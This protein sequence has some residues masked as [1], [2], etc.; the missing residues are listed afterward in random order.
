[1]KR[2]TSS[3]FDKFG[4]ITF[5]FGNMIS[6]SLNLKLANGSKIECSQVITLLEGDSY[7]TLVLKIQNALPPAFNWDSSKDLIRYQRN[8]SQEFATISPSSEFYD[9]LAQIQVR[10]ISFDTPIVLWIFG[11]LGPHSQPTI[12]QNQ[13]DHSVAIHALQCLSA[14]SR[15][16]SQSPLSP[17]FST[18]SSHQSSYKDLHLNDS[19]LDDIEQSAG[20]PINQSKFYSGNRKSCDSSSLS[21]KRNSV[22]EAPILNPVP[23]LSFKRKYEHLYEAR[24]QSPKRRIK[25]LT[26]D[27]IEYVILNVKLNGAAVELPI[28]LE[29]LKSVLEY[30]RKQ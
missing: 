29:S 26:V 30:T 23:R 18:S 24:K 11:S 28:E 9:L 10:N 7:A 3:I 27:G 6:V 2:V 17:V 15:R 8:R 14:G 12:E 1:M 5:T 21:Y 25:T 4:K 19:T 22:V 13:Q 16:S 20:A